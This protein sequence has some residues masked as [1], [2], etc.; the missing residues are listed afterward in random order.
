MI[1]LSSDS[2]LRFLH[3]LAGCGRRC[4]TLFEQG[5]EAFP[6]DTER[7]CHQLPF[8]EQEFLWKLLISPGFSRPPSAHSRSEYRTER[9]MKLA[10]P[11]STGVLPVVLRTRV[12]GMVTDSVWI[13][14]SLQCCIKVVIA[15][16]EEFLACSAVQGLNRQ[17]TVAMQR[18]V[19]RATGRAIGA[20]FSF[21][22]RP[23]PEFQSNSVVRRQTASGSRWSVL[24]TKFRCNTVVRRG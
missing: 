9:R 21:G 24:P 18:P 22:Y 5:R 23:L 8:S 13:S 3:A 17:H 16:R 7:A 15:C 14:N 2:R 19:Q 1:V 20:S 4:A 11:S 6:L 12:C 10:S